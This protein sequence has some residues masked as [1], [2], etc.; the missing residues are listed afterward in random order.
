MKRYCH[1]CG[2]QA[3][4]TA[5]KFC[6][7]CGSSLSFA[8]AQLKV[9]KIQ[10]KTQKADDDE[11]EGEESESSGS[12]SGLSERGLDFEFQKFPTQVEKIEN[13][14]GTRSSTPSDDSDNGQI[15]S[16]SSEEAMKEFQREAGTLRPGKGK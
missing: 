8:S 5:A 3:D 9:E 15:I 2:K 6:C 4:S 14:I 16:L 10:A 7:H 13:V 11:E 1:G 12:Y